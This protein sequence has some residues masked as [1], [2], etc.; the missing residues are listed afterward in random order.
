MG[1]Q[2]QDI[3]PRH[4]SPI[5]SI[6]SGGKERKNPVMI[7]AEREAKKN[8]KGETAK[9]EKGEGVRYM[10][11]SLCIQKAGLENDTKGCFYIKRRKRVGIHRSPTGVPLALPLV[12]AAALPSPRAKVERK[13]GR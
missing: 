9:E 2:Q 7:I 12:R 8:G 3:Q 4:L 5:R 10:H 13:K 6:G 1:S 11:S